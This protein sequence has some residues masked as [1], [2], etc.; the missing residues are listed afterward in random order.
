LNAWK[1]P[2]GVKIKT[3]YDRTVLIRTTME[4]VLDILISGIV[5]VLIILFVFLGHFR[6]AVIVALTVPMA[7]LFT[8]SAMVLVGES[9]NLI[10]LGAIDFGIIVDSTLIMVESIFYHLAHRKNPGLTV[11]EHIMR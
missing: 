6:T 8:F 10:S 11:P 5:L 9:A 2:P 1:L 7:L 4:T 3:F